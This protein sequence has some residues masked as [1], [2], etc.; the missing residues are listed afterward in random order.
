MWENV[1]F[2]SSKQEAIIRQLYAELTIGKAM[3]KPEVHHEKEQ[4]LVYICGLFQESKEIII[5]LI[6]GSSIT[7]NQI[8]AIQ[9]LL[10]QRHEALKTTLALID[11]DSTTVYYSLTPGP[12]QEIRTSNV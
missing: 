5:P 3:L 6:K 1:S 2:S 9:T 10:L 7:M 12:P 8:T 11:D 4:D